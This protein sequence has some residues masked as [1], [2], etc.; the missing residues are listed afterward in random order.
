VG[1]V[2]GETKRDE[3]MKLLLFVDVGVYDR[4]KKK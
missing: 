4:K 3:K 1:D 2:V